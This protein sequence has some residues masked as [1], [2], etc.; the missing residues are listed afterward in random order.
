MI[1]A[2]NHRYRILLETPGGEKPILVRRDQTVWEA[3][4]AAGIEL[5]AMC[6]QGRCLTCA[7]RVVGRAEFDHSAAASYFPEDAAAGFVLLCSAKPRSDARIRTHQE[8][9]MRQHRS[10][11][12]LPAPFA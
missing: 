9:Q 12:G 10:S 4:Q 5:P 8:N 7:G 6:H 3:G 1:V 2:S 11:K